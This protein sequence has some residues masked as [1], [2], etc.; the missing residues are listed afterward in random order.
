MRKQRV[1]KAAKSS[2]SPVI[3]RGENRKIRLVR[4]AD[5]FLLFV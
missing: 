1:I 4:Y 3:Y 2:I 5:D